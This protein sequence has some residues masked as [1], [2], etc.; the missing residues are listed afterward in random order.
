MPTTAKSLIKINF[1][2]I[3][4]FFINIIAPLSNVAFA[5]TIKLLID[6]GVSKNITGLYYHLGVSIVIVI[7]FVCLNYLAKFL[8]NLYSAKR[9]TASRLFLMQ[10]I[11]EMSYA[12]FN[13]QN[14]S[15]YQHLLLNETQQLGD[16]Y[17]KGFFQIA[18]N[19]M[20]ISASLGAMFYSEFWLALVIL[21]ATALPLGLSG[22]SAKKSEKLKNQALLQE[23]SYVNKIKEIIS[24]YVT[25]K[26]YQVENYISTMYQ[27][28]L[29]SYAKSQLRLRGNEAL[30]ATVSELSGLVVFLVAFGG[31]MILTVQGY[32]TIG[33]VTAIVQLVN[34]VV[35]P[36]NDLGLLISRFQSS[37][38]LL[39]PTIHQPLI[40]RQPDLKNKRGTLKKEIKFEQVD[41]KYAP[42]SARV[43]KDLS[44]NFIIGKKYA[45]TGKSGSGKT[46][47]FKLLLQLFQPD[48][49]RIV[50]DQ[51]NLQDLSSAWWYSQLAII[52]QEVFIF[53]D[54]LK[55][56]VTLGRDFSDAAVLS[57]LQQAGLTDFL[58]TI[59]NNLAYSCGENGKNLSGG[60]KQRLSIAR[61][62]LKAKPVVLFD[63]ATSAL[64]EKTGN[65][66]E[67]TLLQKQELT[68][69]AITHKT[70]I[71]GLYDQIF[72]MDQG[73]LITV[74]APS[75]EN[76]LL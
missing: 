14:T 62:F 36:I 64:D 1:L 33:S 19:L 54:T 34:F 46:T 44:V 75:L 42:N 76:R 22:I 69:I 32:T 10:K 63:E 68:V 56:N 58:A 20:L 12:A 28:Y 53:N 26:N 67:N 51:D 39:A 60:Q 23:K 27:K 24:G 16:D 18:R 21:I 61:A 11:L 74:S 4:T 40:A 73:K 47:I 72:K 52:P 65:D 25:I 48:Q 37:K 29:N 15:D 71:S 57:A 3:L 45:I 2:F 30:T 17:L 7:C 43:L 49:G 55:N 9:I 31:G 38:Q 66:I 13:R 50:I 6:D 8:T 5:L 35:L 59:Q 70:N 41:F